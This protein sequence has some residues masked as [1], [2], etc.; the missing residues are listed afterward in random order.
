[1]SDNNEDPPAD[2]IEEEQPDDNAEADKQKE[3]EA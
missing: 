2:K 1:M 3:G